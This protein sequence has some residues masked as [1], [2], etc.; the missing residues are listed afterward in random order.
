MVAAAEMVQTMSPEVETSARSRAAQLFGRI[1]TEQL[2]EMAE[3]AG[4]DSLM[5]SIHK[6]REGDPTARQSIV[7]NVRTDVIERTIKAGHIMK[8]RLEVDDS[9]RV[10]QHGQ[11]AQSIQENSLRYA[12]R[13]RAMRERTQA[14]TRNMF[15]IEELNRRGLLKDYV[16]VVFSRPSDSLSL[17]E[18]ED[19]GF[20]VDT[21]SVAIQATSLESDGSLS[22]ESAFVA[23]KPNPRSQRHDAATMLKLGWGRGV[24]LRNKSDAETIDTPMLIHKSLM[25]N[26]VV[27]VVSWWDDA[28]GGT[29]FGQDKLRQDYLTYLNQCKEREAELEPTVQ[30]IVDQLIA[31]ADSI[32]TPLDATRRLHELSEARTLQRALTDNKIDGTVY[33]VEAAFFLAGARASLEQGD[34]QTADRLL[35]RA[36]KVARSSSCPGRSTG[37]E[38]PSGVEGDPRRRKD[39]DEDCEYTSKECPMCGAK[40]VKT[41]DE[42]VLGEKRRISGSCGCSRTYV[43][44][45]KATISA[46]VIAEL[47]ESVLATGLGQSEFSLAA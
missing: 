19:E 3:I 7:M 25:P 22:T 17:R 28:A 10:L 31:E 39:D 26:G 42:R 21:M 4:T 18:L 45:R 44:E 27:D 41:K 15:R 43:K 2:V 24:D 5:D 32:R 30:S 1:A 8:V 13:S 16:F 47:S 37:P 33:G 46:K 23:G 34:M 12:S 40:N 6:A 36:L 29:F 9:G 38:V 20:F 11:S 35:E 14:E